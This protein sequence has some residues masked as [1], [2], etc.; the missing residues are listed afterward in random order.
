MVKLWRA[1][2]RLA[3]CIV[4]DKQVY[5]S[6]KV[7]RG[8]WMMVGFMVINS[9]CVLGQHDSAIDGKQL[10]ER[11]RAEL[12]LSM[13]QYNQVLAV[14][15]KV[16]PKIKAAIAQSSGLN[17]LKESFEK[18]IE[19]MDISLLKILDGDQ[20]NLWLDLSKSKRIVKEIQQGGGR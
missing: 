11:M 4:V 2:K 12:K 15:Y 10:A 7:E 13:K 3:F 18:I 20:W 16:A 19:E 14:S 1:K 8:L 5:G 17:D 9:A 6:M